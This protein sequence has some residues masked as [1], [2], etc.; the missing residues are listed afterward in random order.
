MQRARTG[1]LQE[2]NEMLF[3]AVDAC[4]MDCVVVALQ[5]GADANARRGLSMQDPKRLLPDSALATA[6]Y[7]GQIQIAKYLLFAGADCD[8]LTVV[9]YKPSFCGDVLVVD[10]LASLAAIFSGPFVRCSSFCVSPLA[11][12]IWRC[13]VAAVDLLLKRGASLRDDS[14]ASMLT[15]A[16]LVGNGTILKMVVAA[17][18]KRGSSLLN[19]NVMTPMLFWGDE[20]V[21][22]LVQCGKT[23]TW[24]SKV[25][26]LLHAVTALNHTECMM[27]CLD[28]GVNMNSWTSPLRC[29]EHLMRVHGLHHGEHL[30]SLAARKC[31]HA[32]YTTLLQYAYV[33]SV[34]N[35][36]SL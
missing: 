13:N 11:I 7:L 18:L 27:R 2:R 4:A 16:I 26:P 17:I 6:I 35:W 33:Q 20:L 36:F 9:A 34:C 5:L 1:A 14:E 3:Q 22:F 15:L 12:A 28:R 19:Q 32:S 8:A 24:P 31:S 21:S 23:G 25:E 30:L 10:G 29:H